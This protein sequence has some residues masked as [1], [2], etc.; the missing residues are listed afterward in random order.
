MFLAFVSEFAFV[1]KGL[2]AVGDSNSCP[3]PT[4]SFIQKLVTVNLG[5][6]S[7]DESAGFKG[8]MELKQD[9]G[10]AV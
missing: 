3:G 6:L 8:T 2:V 9:E 7:P 4:L 10:S 1:L 5:F